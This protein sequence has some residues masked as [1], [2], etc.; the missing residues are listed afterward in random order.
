MT[1]TKT[2]PDAPSKAVAS[3]RRTG[4]QSIDIGATLL[5]VLARH[6][7]PMHLRDIASSAG[8]SAS[9]AHRYLISLQRAGL[10][11]QDPATGR[12]DL[13]AAS[14]RIGLA[15]LNRVKVVQYATQGLIEFNQEEDLTVAL[16]I[17]GDNG[18]TIVGW[19][20]STQLV[21]CNLHIG[22]VL[23]LLRSA[24]GQL[25]LA[26]LPADTTRSMVEK[27]LDVIVN[28]LPQTAIRTRNDV[29]GLIQRIRKQRIGM[30]QED[31]V[32]RLSAYAAPVFDHLG[33]IAATVSLIA[34][35]GMVHG[36]SSERICE[37]LLALADRLS[38]K[39]GREP[40]ALTSSYIEMLERGD[41][42]ETASEEGAV[43]DEKSAEDRKAARTSRTRS[44]KRSAAKEALAD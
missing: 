41:Y 25:F 19:Y 20:D 26:Y 21:I 2:K 3:A 28:Y 24:S 29:D 16:S 39:L 36:V 6:M 40:S 1:K 30:T 37:K 33:R 5:E 10:A 43:A 15:A 7:G 13:G 11:E 35:T 9:K 14:L 8:M 34:P 12:Y 31:L 42:S 22:S 32:P 44:R 27:E 4:V 38:V 18:P 23:P 17:W